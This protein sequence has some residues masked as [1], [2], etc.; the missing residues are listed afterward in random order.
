MVQKSEIKE[1][2]GS[3]FNQYSRRAQG[4]PIN[5]NPQC[6]KV[7]NESPELKRFWQFIDRTVKP[8]SKGKKKGICTGTTWRGRGGAWE[9]QG[10]IIG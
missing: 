7:S 10:K 9:G 4:V 1:N 6:E 5:R 2:F 8:G 3:I